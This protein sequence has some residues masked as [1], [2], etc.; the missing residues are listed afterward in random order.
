MDAT[1][2]GDFNQNFDFTGEFTGNSTV[3][4]QGSV[5]HVAY[6][7]FENADVSL[8]LPLNWSVIRTLDPY[9]IYTNVD[10]K[11]TVYDSHSAPNVFRMI[12]MND[13]I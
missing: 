13:T 8:E 5:Y 6:S 3:E 7:F 10:V 9:D 11:A 4:L 2:Q 12:K 1:A